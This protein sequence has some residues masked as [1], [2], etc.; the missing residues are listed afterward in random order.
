[1]LNV[2]VYLS[3]LLWIINTDVI[4]NKMQGNRVSDY[5]DKN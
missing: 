4:H 2:S 5:T 3:T 1:M